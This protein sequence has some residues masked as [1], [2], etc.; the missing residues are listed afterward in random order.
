KLSFLGNYSVFLYEQLRYAEALEMARKSLQLSLKLGNLPRAAAAYN[1]ISLQLQA[2]GRL[3]E[4]ARNLVRGLEISSAIKVPSKKDLGDRRKYYNN[5]S[6]LM[7]DLNDLKKGLHYAR[8]SYKLAEE[9]QD[10]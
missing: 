9:L 2:Q 8:E 5:L 1:N 6:S 10:S 3:E 7:L 4:A